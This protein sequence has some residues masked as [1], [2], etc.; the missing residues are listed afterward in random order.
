MFLSNNEVVNAAK[1]LDSAHTP[2]FFS[3]CA[4]FEPAGLILVAPQLGQQ[5]ILQPE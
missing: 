3:H 1:G 2:I 5:A 4:S